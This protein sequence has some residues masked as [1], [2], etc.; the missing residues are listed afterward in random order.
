MNDGNMI[1]DEEFNEK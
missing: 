1:N